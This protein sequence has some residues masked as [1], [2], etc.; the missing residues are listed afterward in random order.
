MDKVTCH[1]MVKEKFAR[2]TEVEKQQAVF[3]A[4]K[5]DKG[6]AKDW[7]IEWLNDNYPDKKLLDYCDLTYNSKL[8]DVL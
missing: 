5:M 3:Q 6:K 2:F 1:R 7:I 8:E 4:Y